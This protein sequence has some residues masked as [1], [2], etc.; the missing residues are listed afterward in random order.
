MG[1]LY[2]NTDQSNFAAL[3]QN[4]AQN[5]DSLDQPK[6]KKANQIHQS[7]NEVET[8]C[9]YSFLCSRKGGKDYTVKVFFAWPSRQVFEK[10]K[11]G[12]GTSK[13]PFVYEKSI[14][15]QGSRTEVMQ[16]LQDALY[17]QQG[18]WKRWLWSYGI[19]EAREIKA[20]YFHFDNIAEKSVAPICVTM[21][22]ATAIRDMAQATLDD[23]P[24]PVVYENEDACNGDPH[25]LQCDETRSK[26]NPCLKDQLVKAERRLDGF[27]NQH[28]LTEGLRCPTTAKTRS[29]LRDGLLQETFV[30][31]AEEVSTEESI[32]MPSNAEDLEDSKEVRGVY[33]KLGWDLS[34]MLRHICAGSVWSLFGVAVV[35]LGAIVWAGHTKD[36]S[37]AWAFGQVLAASVALLVYHT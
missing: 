15:D 33:V 1:S 32:L 21:L 20:R 30:Y 14:V 27:R 37:T 6:S 24:P 5:N 22:Q 19:Q 26:E 13:R 34:R 25:T 12:G 11:K 9:N 18:R 31:Q 4:E 23:K 3:S 16:A 8:K 35:W 10:K 2:S 28:W 17:K 29:F 7:K 36:W